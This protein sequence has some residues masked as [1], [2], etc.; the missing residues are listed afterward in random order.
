M[1]WG[2]GTH[3]W[4]RVDEAGWDFSDARAAPRDERRV[5]AVDIAPPETL[6]AAVARVEALALEGA[7][8]GLVWLR[9]DGKPAPAPEQLPTRLLLLIPGAAAGV[10]SSFSPLIRPLG[11]RDLWTPLRREWGAAICGLGWRSLSAGPVEAAE[12]AARRLPQGARLGLLA[13]GEGGL[14]AELFHLGEAAVPA[15]PALAPLAELLRARD[16]RVERC[17]RVATPI[18]GQR[19]EPLHHWV[20]RRLA[21]TAVLPGMRDALDQLGA[22]SVEAMTDQ[23]PG[24]AALDPAGPL[25]RGLHLPGVALPGPLLEVMGSIAPDAPEAAQLAARGL[26]HPGD[27][28]LVVP[29]AVASGG[30]RRVRRLRYSAAIT[31]GAWLQ[32]GRSREVIGDAIL[33]IE[34]A[35]LRSADR[36]IRSPRRGQA[37]GPVRYGHPGREV[38]YLVPG[39]FASRLRAPDG[40]EWPDIGHLLL[41]GLEPFRDPAM[42]MQLLGILEGFYAP[43]VEAL[44]R[45][46]EVVVFPYDWRQEVFSAAAALREAL[47]V[48]LAAGRRVHLVGHSLGGLV[49]RA[50]TAGLPPGT[51]GALVQL[52]TPNQGATGLLRVL[53]GEDPRIGL[54]DLVLP[55]DA[56]PEVFAGWPS[57]ADL[58]PRLDPWDPALVG[59]ARPSD[60]ALIAAALRRARLAAIPLPPAFAFIAGVGRLTPVLGG[61]RP[62]ADGDGQVALAEGPP[63]GREADGVVGAP[64]TLLARSGPVIGAILRHLAGDPLGLPLP[65]AGRG[66][67]QD[68]RVPPPGLPSGEGLLALLDGGA[69]PEAGGALT[70]R[71]LHASV[72]EASHPVLFGHTEGAPLDGVGA[73]LDEVLDQELRRRLPSDEGGIHVVLRRRRDG[74][75]RG[76]VAV[77]L[78]APG[79]LTPG[80]LEAAVRRALSRYLAE[81]GETAPAEPLGASVVLIGTRPPEVLTVPVVVE[82]LVEAACRVRAESRL[83]ELEIVSVAEGP[84]TQAWLSL[85]QLRR[86]AEDRLGFVLAPAPQRGRTA[87]DRAPPELLGGPPWRHVGLRCE[88]PVLHWLLAEGRAR[89]DAHAV[90]VDRAEADAF[91]R[92]ATEDLRLTA[93]PET[94]NEVLF[95]LLVPEAVAPALASGHGLVLTVDD[96][97]AALPWEAIA[98]SDPGL[99]MPPAVRGG[100]IRQLATGT[101]R[102]P[103]DTDAVGALLLGEPE[104]PGQR[105]LPAVRGEI[106]TVERAFRAAGVPCRKILADAPFGGSPKGALL[107]HAARYLHVA[108]HGVADEA[109]TA[110]LLTDLHGSG[111]VRLSAADILRLP[112]LPWVVFLNACYSG[113]LSAGAFQSSLALE[114]IRGGVR[115]VVV[116][117]WAVGD[118][119]A[120]VF[121]T[122]FYASLLEGQ[123]FGEAVLAARRDAWEVGRG[124][125]STWSAYQC[126]GDPAFRPHAV[127]APAPMDSTSAVLAQLDVA[128]AAACRGETRLPA[129]VETLRAPDPGPLA[130]PALPRHLRTGPVLERAANVADEAD[131]RP[132]AEELYRA[133][134]A[135]PGERAS[136]RALE[137]LARVLIVGA[138]LEVEAPRAQRR[139]AIAEARDILEALV[140]LAPTAKVYALLGDCRAAEAAAGPRRADSLR[141]A[142]E[143]Y[144]EDPGPASAWAQATMRLLLGLSVGDLERVAE[145]RARE[146]DADEGDTELAKALFHWVRQ[147]GEAAREEAVRIARDRRRTPRGRSRADARIQVI[148]GLS[149]DPR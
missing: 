110:V 47:L 95:R 148:R 84:A 139:K 51:I 143:A 100:L 121:A 102:A 144:A 138:S 24:L 5:T 98:A 12:V 22:A 136:L 147:P 142:V 4:H 118:G 14:V 109:G 120:A 39:I 131:H 18:R 129:L 25:I 91:A 81:R 68:L 72:E 62:F 108:A 16:V 141:A 29:A 107:T 128:F 94:P 106:D 64:H 59:A 133:A 30:L 17:V 56:V 33:G 43:L 134:L 58:L 149:E 92:L 69:P 85:Q 117:G 38:V 66:P 140:R 104:T 61:P 71:V 82:A 90:A 10:L 119:P 97:A 83:D 21:A 76:A 13:L 8:P 70:V 145:A 54:V 112:E 67:P 74:S 50:A 6:D 125:D 42:P 78:G 27:G 146:N 130:I 88:G 11:G 93:S 48:E 49:A 103:R 3:E 99:H 55:R 28:D 40:S 20:N 73:L 132:E 60:G 77:P 111:A 35:A 122:S 116:C 26:A 41:R 101:P 96:D 79:S 57:V 114:L 7:P 23:L 63:T 32:G 115:C 46:R 126:Y 52:G 36:P 135:L 87:R 15:P 89:V 19:Q 75:L 34:D 105:A 65:G 37:G 1:R 80:S 44:A 113:R 31:H 45:G 2:D 124:V 137:G 9:E 127:P 53:R 123:S 86:R